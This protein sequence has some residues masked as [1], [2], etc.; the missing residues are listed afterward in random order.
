MQDRA[1]VPGATLTQTMQNPLIVV[2]PFIDAQA[3]AVRLTHTSGTR[4]QEEQCSPKCVPGGPGPTPKGLGS[5]CLEYNVLGR[6]RPRSATPQSQ[7]G[8]KT[9]GPLKKE[10]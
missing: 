2:H 6:T 9:K 10:H 3:A 4:R 8:E 5:Q 1:P 7:T